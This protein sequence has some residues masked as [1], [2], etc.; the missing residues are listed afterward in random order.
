METILFVTGAREYTRIDDAGYS[1]K[2]LLKLVKNKA[3]GCTIRRLPIEPGWDFYTS[4]THVYGE[5]ITTMDVCLHGLTAPPEEYR[6]E[7]ELAEANRA[8]S[9]SFYVNG[10]G[11]SGQEYFEALIKNNVVV[12]E[13]ILRSCNQ[14]PSEWQKAFENYG[15][16]VYVW[17][18]GLAAVGAASTYYTWDPHVRNC[19]GA[20][21]YELYRS[22]GYLPELD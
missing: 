8:C 15:L 2:R 17:A 22:R 16:D 6:D 9:N 3:R 11:R 21:L 12:N 4:F 5:E 7:T 20:L 10:I 13:M 18:P 19:Q 14:Y 1:L